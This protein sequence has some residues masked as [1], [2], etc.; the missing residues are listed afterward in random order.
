MNNRA[1]PKC[2][3]W[4][5]RCP[6]PQAR[7]FTNGCIVSNHTVRPDH[8]AVR[9]LRVRPDDCILT[10]RDLLADGGSFTD[11]GGRGHTGMLCLDGVKSGEQGKQL[12]ERLLHD[13]SRP[14]S[15]R[16]V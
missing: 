15:A 13:Y 2:S 4:I 10:D 16:G 12:L 11:A 6:W 8:D 14:R 1:R 5:D 3:P 7:T 9:E